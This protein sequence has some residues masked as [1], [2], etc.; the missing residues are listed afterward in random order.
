MGE[1]VKVNDGVNQRAR[2]HAE[3]DMQ[4]AERAKQV[5]ELRLQGWEFDAIAE[6]CG[7]AS[8]SGA[9][10]TW[11]RHLRSMSRPALEDARRE[12]EMRLN[13]A[14]RL[15][16]PKLVQSDPRAMEALAKLE[17]RRAKLFGMDAPSE[18]AGVSAQPIIREYQPG[19]VE[20]V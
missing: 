8:R 10:N 7:Y 5:I 9:Y 14:I 2:A 3:Q 11:K 12:S 17:E 20:S 15:L 4:A 1:A 18:Q 13:R 6:R 16:E 19:I